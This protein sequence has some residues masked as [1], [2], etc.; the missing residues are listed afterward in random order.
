MRSRCQP[1][2]GFEDGGFSDATSGVGR[3]RRPGGGRARSGTARR[4]G[5]SGQACHAPSSASAPTWIGGELVHHRE[6]NCDFV[7]IGREA[8]G[9]VAAARWPSVDHRSPRTWSRFVLDV[10]RREHDSP[11]ERIED[12]EA[13]AEHGNAEE[14]RHAVQ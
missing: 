12:S 1:G 14:M 10:R 4:P 7:R 3:G 9:N 5:W 6:A 13:P 8:G 2:F 11:V